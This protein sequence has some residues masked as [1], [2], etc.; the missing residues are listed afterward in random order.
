MGKKSFGI[1][2]TETS[3][4]TIIDLQSLQNARNKSLKSKLKKVTDKLETPYTFEDEEDT[5]N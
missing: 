3:E 2:D 4:E 5:K 1:R